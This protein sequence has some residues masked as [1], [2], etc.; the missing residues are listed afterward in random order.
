M[1]L[2]ELC[3]KMGLNPKSIALHQKRISQGEPGSISIQD[4]CRIDN[5]ALLPYSHL[6]GEAPGEG[7]VAFVPAAGAASRY[8]SLF[9]E[10]KA[11]SQ[12]Q[13]N[14]QLTTAVEQITKDYPETKNWPLPPKLKSVFMGET[15]TTLSTEDFSVLAKEMAYPKALMPCTADDATFLDIKSYEHQNL[16][17]L[18]GQTF[19]V[20]P[21][22]LDVV[23][24]HMK[25]SQ[26][27]K[28]I[29]SQTL[30]QDEGLSTVRF[31]E[32]H[33]PI[34]EPSGE[35]SMVPA[36]HGALTALF[37]KVKESF[38][39]AHSLF[40]R[41]ID[42]VAGD[43]GEAAEAASRIMA[44]HNK[45]R[46]YM[47][48]IRDGLK[49]GLPDKETI[50]ALSEELGLNPA[51]T[52][53][54]TQELARIA[55]DGFYTPK[56]LVYQTS[57]TSEE[58]LRKSLRTIFKRPFNIMGQVPNTGNDVGGSAIFT[59]RGLGLE[60]F[61]IEVPHASEADKASF[62][63]NPSK[64]THFNPVFCCAEIPSDP[65]Y[66]EKLAEDIPWLLAKKK[67]AGKDVYYHETVLYEIIGSSRIANVIFTEVP[68][69]VFNPH[70]TMADCK[71]LG[72]SSLIKNL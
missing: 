47:E 5:G 12:S 17:E 61:C 40:I 71:M 54:P 68:R 53:D 24:E 13:N 18:V 8:L 44:Y 57:D 60:T 29:N 70:K 46:N 27:F 25:D 41:N 19:I 4:T 59:D 45:L 3:L 36:G 43:H 55:I 32:N 26:A 67:Y 37:P 15:P 34:I 58:D 1:N 33:Q 49:D 6:K 38:A 64:A 63:A 56:G 51:E 39:E 21:A 28:N 16:P 7:Y 65:D 50:R 72:T 42:N 22:H 20:G 69:A 31:G 11:A 52:F 48:Q 9:S 62:L 14:D 2:V 10:V 66:Y 23:T 35:L 30:I